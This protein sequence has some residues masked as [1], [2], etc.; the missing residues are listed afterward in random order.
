MALP[1][2][3][4]DPSEPIISVLPRSVKLFT[5]FLTTSFLEQAKTRLVNTETQRLLKAKTKNW[6]KFSMFVVVSK[7]SR[8]FPRFPNFLVNAFEGQV[9]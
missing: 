3:F 5:G 1:G 4:K 9:S 8:D 6:L 7:F 2:F